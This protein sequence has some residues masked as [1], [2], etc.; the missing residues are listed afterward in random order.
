MTSTMIMVNDKGPSDLAT[1]QLVYMVY[2]KYSLKAMFQ[3]NE[4]T[5]QDIRETE[6]SA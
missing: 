2:Y 1:G 3:D 4:P 5:E 6:V